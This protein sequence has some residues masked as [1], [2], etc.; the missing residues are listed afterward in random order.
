MGQNEGFVPDQ[1]NSV[2][3]AADLPEDERP[4]VQ[5]LDTTSAAFS[6]WIETQSYSDICDIEVPSRTL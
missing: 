6:A 3:I 1:M 5:V 2:R 4:T